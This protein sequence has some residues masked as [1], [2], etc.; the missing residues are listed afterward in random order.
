MRLEYG[1]DQ[2]MKFRGERDGW[3]THVKFYNKFIKGRNSGYNQGHGGHITIKI[4]T[5]LGSGTVVGETGVISG[6][7]K[8]GHFPSFKLRGRGAYIKKNQTYYLEFVN[9]NKTNFTSLNYLHNFR[10]VNP[11]SGWDYLRNNFEVYRKFRGVWYT[12]KF[13]TPI[14]E[15]KYADG[16]VGG[17]GYV[18]GNRQDPKTIGG[19][20]KV[21][22]VFVPP[23]NMRVTAANIHVF[24][25]AGNADNLRV[26]VLNS[27]GQ[28]VTS[29][30]ISSRSVARSTGDFKG[31]PT[32]KWSR[33]G[34]RSAT[35]VKGQ[36]YYIVLECKVKSAYG[37]ISVQ[38]GW[39]FGWRDSKMARNCR[40]QWSS[41]GGR[42]WSG[43]KMHGKRNRDDC[44]LPILMET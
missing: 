39:R 8:Y 43:F 27:K 42:S 17:Q 25:R 38:D 23:K 31:E 20:H 34:M 18:Q 40:G 10:L 5:G 26:L 7:Y 1:R 33:C 15:L 13:L 30:T 9:T 35:L 28:T 19:P 4:R 6:I 21:R 37:I 16:Y 2:A 29:G 12:N 36:T 22:Q 41:S 32:V 11:K 24:K 44:V 3:V 14:F